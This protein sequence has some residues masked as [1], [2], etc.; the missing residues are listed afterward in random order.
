MVK[1]LA[2]D[3]EF[4]KKSIYI[5]DIN[6]DSDGTTLLGQI[7]EDLKDKHADGA[8]L[9]LNKDHHGWRSQ[10]KKRGIVCYDNKVVYGKEIKYLAQGP[11]QSGIQEYD[12]EINDDLVKLSLEAGKYSRFRMDK[13][14]IDKFESLYTKWVE[15][16]LLRII[17]DTVLVY[18]NE[19]R[20]EGLITGKVEGKMAT[21]GLIAT[22]PLMQ[23]K[24][25]GMQLLLAA[26]LEFIRKGAIKVEV[27]TQL[28]NKQ[29]CTFYEKCGYQAK[30]VTPIY[31]IWL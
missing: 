3:S 30:S 22:N 2:W 18:K 14:F 29:A 16:S 7:I 24:G 15:N 1:Y 28:G 19:N 11:V 20:I 5:I 23:R 17:A 25:I 27:A 31:H 21:I 8:Y 9:I 26:E 10:L 12:G 4:F 13:H 6:T